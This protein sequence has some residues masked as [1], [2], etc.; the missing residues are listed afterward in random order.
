[1]YT[2]APNALPS[3]VPQAPDSKLALRVGV[4]SGSCHGYQYTMDLTE[5]RGVDD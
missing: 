2:N 5:D 1:M 3:R 4:D